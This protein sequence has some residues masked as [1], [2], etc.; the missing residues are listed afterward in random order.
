MRLMRTEGSIKVIFTLPWEVA[1]LADQ[2]DQWVPLYTVG[3]MKQIGTIH[4]QTYEVQL[5]LDTQLVDRQ[6][7]VLGPHKK[8]H[9]S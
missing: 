8:D 9:P 4:A 1:Y 3:D 5:T 7:V 6:V 2:G